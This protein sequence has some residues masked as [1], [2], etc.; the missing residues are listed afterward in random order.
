M[1]DDRLT[2]EEFAALRK[3]Y[4]ST[5][6]KRE[7]DRIKAVR[8]LAGGWSVEQVAEI[9]QVDANRVRNHFKS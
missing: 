5:R 8:L 2:A 6:A 9:M 7:A 3:A 1:L 4:R